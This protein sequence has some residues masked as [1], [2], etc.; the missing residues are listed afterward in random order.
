M[1][2]SVAKLRAKRHGLLEAVAV[3]LPD[4]QAEAA[5]L[6]EAAQFPHASFE[7]LRGIGLLSATLPE[8]LGGL[9]FGYGPQGAASLLKLLMLLG[10][11]SLP[12]GRLYEAHVNA[13][14]LICRYGRDNLAARAGQDAADGH[15][16]ALWVTDPPGGG[17]LRLR[18]DFLLEGGKAFCS[19]AGV[20][21][22]ALVTAQTAAGAQM[23]VVA[24]PPQTRTLPS[25]IKLGGMRAAI[26]G[27]IDFSGMQVA[28]DDVLGSIGD[29]LREPVFSAGAWRSAAAALGGLAALVKLH[30]Q[31]ILRRQRQGDPHQQARFGQVMIAYETSHLWMREAAQRGCLEDDTDEAIV[32]YINLARLAVEAACLDAMRFTQRS[33]GLS[34]FM[35]GN[36]AELLCR[37][38]ATY[39]RQPAPDETLTKAASFYLM[40]GVPEV[41]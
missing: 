7:H 41:S 35:A 9:G 27:S 29:Y 6:D 33:L 21:T 26:T 25:K 40:A 34:A 24:L 12:V 31:E 17:G 28:P 32:A 10:E 2:F 23:L 1:H 30:R 14:Q 13:L 19:G 4:I 11:A 18:P 5:A 39:L 16:F 3:A 8:T 22:R 15:L 36:P 20:A 38:L 37:D